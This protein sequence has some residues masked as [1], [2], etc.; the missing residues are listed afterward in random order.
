MSK[1]VKEV[2]VTGKKRRKQGGAGTKKH[3]RNLKKCAKYRAEGRREKN[4][5]RKQKKILKML[6]KKIARKSGRCK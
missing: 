2:V 3:G 1:T 6:Q 4:K 5:A